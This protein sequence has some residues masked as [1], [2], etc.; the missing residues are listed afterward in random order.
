MSRLS[1]PLI[2]LLILAVSAVAAPS[3]AAGGLE[4]TRWDMKSA[5]IGGGRD[6]LAF[7][8]GEFL[9]EKYIQGG[10]MSVPYDT[11]ETAGTVVWTATTPNKS[12]KRLWQ[13][14]W[15][16]KSDEMQGIVSYPAADGSIKTEKW[17]ARR[18]T[19]RPR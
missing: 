7:L 5:G 11:Q 12:G 17:S 3:L 8:R 13:G 10:G 1:F 16:G 14:A 19:F 2:G 9:S 18:T 15:D 6:H 4:G